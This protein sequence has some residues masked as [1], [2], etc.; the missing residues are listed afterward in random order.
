VSSPEKDKELSRVT[1][2][3]EDRKSEAKL[4][5]KRLVFESEKFVRF[6]PGNYARILDKEVIEVSHAFYISKSL[7]TNSEY[8]AIIDDKRSVGAIDA[9]KPVANVTFRQAVEYCNKLS[10][11]TKGCTKVYE[12][13]GEGAQWK[14][15]LN[16]NAKGYRLPFE[17]EWEC[18]LDDNREM[19]VERPD[20]FAKMLDGLAWYHDNS[21]DQVRFV[22]GKT[23]TRLAIYDLLGNI[24]EWCFDNNYIDN[25]YKR[26]SLPPVDTINKYRYFKDDSSTSRVLRGG[27]SSS[28]KS[29][30]TR[31]GF[32]KKADETEK[33]NLGF[34][35]VFQCGEVEK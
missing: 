28:F 17:A 3:L 15:K 35:I 33:T 9:R 19:L 5:D 4:P 30:F 2:T 34:R 22:G 12:I 16:E 25:N 23:P 27:C 13:T 7:V 1:G 26:D 10:E 21:D 6:N 18:A 14:V 29:V 20:T 31:T 11:A 24:W 8:W 32:R